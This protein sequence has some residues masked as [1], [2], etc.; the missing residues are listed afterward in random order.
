MGEVNFA[1]YGT[2][3][4]N[5]YTQRTVDEFSK[6]ETKCLDHK[7]KII[8]PLAPKESYFS[9]KTFTESL[10][11]I[12]LLRALWKRGMQRCCYL[13]LFT[14]SCW[15]GDLSGAQRYLKYNPRKGCF[16]TRRCSVYPSI[17]ACVHM[18]AHMC[19]G[20]RVW[21]QSVLWFR[22][23]WKYHR[24]Y[25]EGCRG[26]TQGTHWQLQ[27]GS[28]SGLYNWGFFFNMAKHVKH[29]PFLKGKIPSISTKLWT[30]NLFYYK[31]TAHFPSWSNINFGR[32][33]NCS[34]FHSEI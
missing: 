30:A 33:L 16:S 4:G 7:P 25:W 19:V 26:P 28:K 23:W 15:T 29:V 21:A 11:T 20:D 27:D 2:F 22:V 3:N 14:I 34:D 6:P 18:C 24:G 10:V 13:P 1:K 12:L 8:N 17:S 31:K 9:S 32:Q 5:I